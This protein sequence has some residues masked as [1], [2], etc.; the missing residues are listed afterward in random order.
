M[1]TRLACV[2]LVFWLASGCG[3]GVQAPVESSSSA[4]DQDAAVEQAIQ[5]HLAKRTD[6]NLGGMDIA[7]ERITYPAS[8]EARAEVAFRAKGQAEAMLE[9]VYRLDRVEDAWQVRPG[10][11]QGA[12]GAPQ[13]QPGGAMPPDHPP[14]G[15]TPPSGGSGSELPPGHPPV[16]Q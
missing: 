1:A 5:A 10:A 11:A 2:T 3:G 13:T 14:V 8:D 4:A 9:M 6:L 15:G 16:A 7:V 12:A